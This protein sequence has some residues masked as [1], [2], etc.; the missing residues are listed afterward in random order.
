MVEL[1]STSKTSAPF[2]LAIAQP[3]TAALLATALYPSL[4]SLFPL[5]MQRLSEAASP[6]LRILWSGGA[7][8]A[9]ALAFAVPLL[10]LWAL[11]KTPP[12]ATRKAIAV[13]R[14]LH[15]AFA[16][17]PLYG[18]TRLVVA[19][20][21]GVGDWHGPAWLA[22]WIAA[23]FL[24]AGARGDRAVSASSSSSG[25][26]LRGVHGATAIFLFV[27]FIFVHI[28]NHGM[29]LW[30]VEQQQAWMTALRLWYRA[31]WVEPFLLGALVLMVLT[32]IPLALRNTRTGGNLWKTMQSAAGI[33]IVVFLFSH[34]SAVMLARA[35]GRNTDWLFATGQN[36]LI[37][38]LSSQI[39][40]YV[41]S[42]A[43]VMVHG[44]IGVRMAL[45]RRGV[46]TVVVGRAFS[47]SMWCAGLMTAWVTA[48]ILGIELA[49]I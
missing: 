3:W 11:I 38:G 30:S 9:M 19:N 13:R 40:Y 17:A 45:L 33:Y 36:G 29:A 37:A 20:R 21:L 44:A 31:A 35:A 12:Q 22:A 18:F 16:A 14:A 42:I 25:V 26:L 1:S 28:L 15:T 7:L 23:A 34:V 10:A 49:G 2:S 8:V 43:V 27:G 48:A 46:D 32:G 5:A 47:I 4:L 24:L 6:A 41:L 39:P